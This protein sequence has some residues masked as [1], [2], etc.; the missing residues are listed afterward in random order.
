MMMKFFNIKTTQ[1]II[2]P[3]WVM[4]FFILSACSAKISLPPAADGKVTLTSL[5]EVSYTTTTA[6]LNLKGKNNLPDATPFTTLRFYSNESCSS[7]PIGEG[8][9]QVFQTSGIQIT[10]PSTQTSPIYANTNTNST[11]TLITSY[12]PLHLP[13]PAPQFAQFS[14][15]SPTRI[16]T[17]PLITGFVSGITLTVQFFS[18]ASCTTLVGSGLASDFTTNGISLTLTANTDNKVYAKSLEPFGNASPCTLL[19]HFVH[20]TLGP[21]NPT[22]TS[23]TPLSPNNYSTTPTLIGTSDASTVTLNLFGDSTC[24]SLLA[25]GTKAQYEGSGIQIS[26]TPNT[27]TSIYAVAVDQSGEA[28]FCTFLTTYYHN[29]N[30]PTAPVFT[31]IA[32]LSPSNS[33]THPKLTG[34]AS[35]N[36]AVINFYSDSLCNSQIGSGTKANFIGSGITINVAS[37]ASTTIYAQAVDSAGNLSPCARMTS[38]IHDTIP[39]DPPTFVQTTPTS[40]NNITASPHVIGTASSDTDHVTL[41]KDDACA[42]PLATGSNDAFQNLGIQIALTADV[43][44]T[45]YAISYDLAG[46]GSNCTVLTTYDYSDIIPPAPVFVSSNPAS[47]SNQ[48]FNGVSKPYLS[49]ALSS[50]ITAVKIF[51]NSTCTTQVGSGSASFFKGSGVQ[52]NLPLNAVTHLYAFALDKYLNQSP[53]TSL[54]TFTHTDIQPSPPTYTSFTPISPNRIS[55]TPTVIG[56]A[57]NNPQ[58]IIPTNTVNF[59]DSSFCINSIGTDTKANFTSTGSTLN[60]I[61]N[62]TTHVYAKAF[63][64]AGNGSDCTYL[65]D[66]T[67]DALTPAKPIKNSATPGSPSYSQTTI[68]KGVYGTT[69]DFMP[70]TTVSIYGESSCLTTPLTTMPASL[71]T[72]TGISVTVPANTLTPLYGQTEN[73][74]G[75]VSACNLLINFTHSNVAPT[76]F[77]AS[78]QAN[79]GVFLS[80][81][82]DNVASP[83]PTYTV[84]RS[85]F[86]GGPYSIIA[87]N[88]FST[89]FSD[90]NTSNNTIYYYVV[91]SSNSTGQSLNS[92]EVNVTTSTTAPVPPLTLTATSKNS[93][94]NLSWVNNASDLTY[95]LYRAT[96]SSGP[97]T[98]LK[99][100]ITSTSYSDTSTSNGTPFY[101]VVTALNA[102]G[103]SDYS[104]EAGSTALASPSS[105]TL[106][107]AA[108]SSTACSGAGGVVLTWGAPAYY[109]L[110]TVYAT[111]PVNNQ[112]FNLGTTL[113]K[114]FSHCITSG[115]HTPDNQMNYTV[116][117]KYGNVAGNSSNVASVYFVTTGLSTI[118]GDSMITLNW[119]PAGNANYYAVKYSTTSGGPYTLLTTADS[120]TFQYD[121]TGLQNGKAYYYVVEPQYTLGGNSGLLSN[122]AQG[123]PGTNPGNPTNLVLTINNNTPTLYWNAP[124]RYNSFNIYTATSSSGPWTLKSSYTPS[125]PNANY[126]TDYSPNVGITYYRV[127]A[128]WGSS[129]ESTASNFVSFRNGVTTSLT[130]AASGSN[131]KL[132]WAAVSG[133]SNYN[134][135]RATS[136]TGTYTLKSSTAT[137]PYTDSTVTAGV[138]YFYKVSAN[139]ADGTKGQLSG[140]T[141]FMTGT[142]KV[143]SGV[144]VTS[145]TSSL[146]NLSWAPVPSATGYIIYYGTT[147]NGPY[148]N[149]VTGILSTAAYV[150]GLNS[151]ATYY[152]TVS[153][154]VGG[155]EYAKSAQTSAFTIASPTQPQVKNGN[156]GT[157]VDVSWDGINGATTYTLQRSTDG[158]NFNT[159]VAAGLTS[160]SYNDNDVALSIGQ[161]YFYR[162]AMVYPL[163][164]LYSP[165]SAAIN[166]AETPL[167]PSGLS[168]TQNN[169]GTE[170]D[171]TWAAV[172]E[173]SGYQI[174][175]YSGGVYTLLP[176][177]P[178]SASE[179]ILGLTANTPYTFAV[180]SMNGYNESGYSTTYTVVP[181]AAP[182]APTVTISQSDANTT[183]IS[184]VSVSNATSYSL[185][186]STDGVKYTNLASGINTTTYTHSGLTAGQSYFYRFT[187]SFAG[188]ALGATSLVST[189]ITPV[190]SL[191][192]PTNLIATAT[193]NTTV[194]FSWIQS[195][196]TVNYQL[197]RSAVSGG[198]YTAVGGLLANTAS[199]TSD[200]PPTSSTYYYVLTAINDS[201]VE[202]AASN[203]AS[204]SLN[205]LPTGLSASSSN[206]TIHL[207]WNAVA[208]AS[209]Y[210]LQRGINPSG[211]FSPIQT[212]NSLSYDDTQIINGTTYYY[213][214]FANFGDGSHSQITANT[215]AVAISTMNLQVPIELT[216]QT[217]ASAMT[218]NYA[219]ERS[220]TYLD[221]NAYN[222]TITMDLEVVAQNADSQ[223]HLVSLVDS[224]GVSQGSVSIPPNLNVPKRIRASIANLTSTD[225]YRIELEGTP[226]AGDL[227]VW[228]AKL[229]IT[230][231]GAS[232]TKIY[233]PMMS[234]YASPNSADT[235]SKIASNQSNAYIALANSV[236]YKRDTS[237]F[238]NLEPSN[239]WEMEAVVSVGTGDT[240]VLG[241]YNTTQGAVVNDSETEITETTPTLTNISLEEG[242]TNFGS[243]NEGNEFQISVRCSGTCNQGVAIYKAGIWVSLSQLSK[244]EV[245]FRN[246]LGNTAL[247]SLIDQDDGRSMINTGLFTNP[248]IYLE[249]TAQAPL[250][251]GTIT[252][253]L[254]DASTSDFGLSG[255][256]PVS[257]SS[258]NIWNS[259]LARYRTNTPFTLSSGDRFV[260]EMNPSDTGGSVVQSVIVI[261]TVK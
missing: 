163:G 212:A 179:T 139:F 73:S 233:I 253:Q 187:P 104:N 120:S 107:T 229:L 69:S 217:M 221:P 62:A 57:P 87:S 208:S 150:S 110:F 56:T 166:F 257:G 109:D 186:F 127:T 86:S 30:P 16:S 206:K 250:N 54:T 131:I 153:A 53:C 181:M 227:Q 28:S 55:T 180:T 237:V 234:L 90:L 13:P 44:N 226:N 88:L 141:S 194:G 49:G 114:T 203:E 81:Q 172:N 244:A 105:P 155:V 9:G 205:A 198:P 17:T 38:F 33:T 185:D 46:N 176:Y 207:S 74:I 173:A 77:T 40:P 89:H 249:T 29:T 196:N 3:M 52:V 243:T 204:V 99:S 162:I 168:V 4:V 192:A 178:S 66:Y 148:P 202:S 248:S 100:N 254:M 218:T 113:Q 25:S 51:S 31:T 95:N 160:Q 71:W 118:V 132:T 98:L 149:S 20:S 138:G 19:A 59:Y 158:T 161:I 117:P 216:D 144:G 94:I 27:S 35:T 12:D 61:S 167:V 43:V 129:Y 39:P 122:E 151:N 85:R 130:S 145:F 60:A 22:F 111:D 191:L 75:S 24:S 82:A 199:T 231:T 201:G 189:S 245:F 240:G 157:G 41:F 48:S 246:S 76:S 32:P 91:Q 197:K 242:V 195:P 84:K 261:D 10:L 259:Q 238:S 223:A 235:N 154:I 50:T 65:N 236:I 102:L 93:Q 230:Q 103:E 1:S 193:S 232:K 169:L 34:T 18:D 67:H 177:T 126:F 5:S 251:G 134:V 6:V 156:S 37:N 200:T 116:I 224:F 137:S 121:H 174:Y 220:Q 258:I 80:W 68:L 14:P 79:G 15:A 146:V 256:T 188:G 184:W 108:F 219:F 260:T 140:T 36:T 42:T 255:L 83:M 190:N 96:Q 136:A 247:T 72:S 101:Y 63:D 211:P 7:T 142:S 106:L 214:V 147:N 97:Y 228:S 70:A 222:G 164:T 119:S 124:L 58:A 112:V 252:L 21:N 239:P 123:I 182:A 8:T 128:L 45:I 23:I 115:G 159:T 2:S 64:A 213:N 241:L 225:V 215:S 133:A 183:Q 210:T 78:P 26:V 143:P 135:Y 165:I 152:F 170:V 125:Q 171:L 92:S 209:S 47:P 11:C 175:S